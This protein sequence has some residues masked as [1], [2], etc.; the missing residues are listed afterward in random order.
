QD[1]TAAQQLYSTD[2]LRTRG[3]YQRWLDSFG[4]ITHQFAGTNQDS[5]ISTR[6][7]VYTLVI[8]LMLGMLATAGLLTS[9]L[10]RSFK[11][12]IKSLMYVARSISAGELKH[13]LSLGR[14]DEFGEM[15]ESLN[16]MVIN[17]RK[18]NEDLTEQIKRLRETR[19]ELYETQNQLALQEQMMQQEQMAALGRL[20]AGVAH[21]INNPISFVYSNTV[22][23]GKSVADLRR[24]LELFDGCRN[25]PSD[26]A[27]RVQSLKE[28]IDYDYLVNDLSSAIEDCHEG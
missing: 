24:L 28:E 15:A 27:Q 6:S 20:V 23:L 9:Y 18:M 5:L 10:T 8:I 26:L 7:L 19:S 1:F 3:A 12:P 11:T 25:L 13:T 2:Y 4:E 14:K 16:L 21:E 17:L 22:L